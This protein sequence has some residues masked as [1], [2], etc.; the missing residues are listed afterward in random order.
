M[1]DL[2]R[3][4]RALAFAADKH[5]NQR[6]KDREASPYINHPIRVATILAAE[7]HV[8]D[9]AT[10]I[11]AVLHDT[12]ED[13]ETTFEELEQHFGRH[14]RALVQEVTDDKSLPKAMRKEQQIAHASVASPA[15]KQIKI[16]DKIS[17][18]RD[19][20]DSPPYDWP[21]ERKREY[22]AWAERVVEG[23]RGVNTALDEAFDGALAKARQVLG[24]DR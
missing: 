5:R 4:F 17:N 23:C 24:V 10:L 3:L 21:L 6:R 15:A 11:G 14:I 13:T 7:G 2:E 22:L 12:V 18:I 9:G 19:I 16:A 8:T 20:A 1:T